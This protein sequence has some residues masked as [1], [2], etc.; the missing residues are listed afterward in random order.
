MADS[1]TMWAWIGAV[2][3]RLEDLRV[4]DLAHEAAVEKRSSLQEE[5]MIRWPVG[6]HL[7]LA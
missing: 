5:W 4:M 3:P 1:K 2:R 7:Q 6:F